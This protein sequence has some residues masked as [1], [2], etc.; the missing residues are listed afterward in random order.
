MRMRPPRVGRRYR[1]ELKMG[2]GLGRGGA[3]AEATLPA[4]NFVGAWFKDDAII[5]GSNQVTSWPGR[6]GSG[7]MATAGAGG[8]LLR[9]ATG[10]YH[11][12]GSFPTDA[13]YFTLP[14]QINLAGQFTIYQIYNN[15]SGA[16]V[17]LQEAGGTDAIYVNNTGLTE[18]INSVN[19]NSFV[20]PGTGLCLSRVRR[21]AGDA[22]NGQATGVA[23]VTGASAGGTL[24]FDNC[25]GTVFGTYTLFCKFIGLVVYSADTVV[26]GTDTAIRSYIF[27]ETGASL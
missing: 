17:A 23:E 27:D 14:S 11:P 7:T 15:S 8:L 5:N 21:G 9:D 3:S 24:T 20:V 2:V 19:V 13:R 18:T 6:Q 12:G 4:A 10:I 26:A 16:V 25:M 22:T 1:P